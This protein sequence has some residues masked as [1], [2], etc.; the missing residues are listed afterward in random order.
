MSKITPLFLLAAA[1]S[2]LAQRETPAALFEKNCAICHKAGSDTRAPLPEAMKSL[3]QAAVLKA[4]ESGSMMPHAKAAAP[5]QGREDSA[6]SLRH[7]SALSGRH[8]LWERIRWL[9]S[10]TRFTTG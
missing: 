9:R 5:R 7:S 6:R 3:T 4:L 8:A 10:R 2:A 1:C